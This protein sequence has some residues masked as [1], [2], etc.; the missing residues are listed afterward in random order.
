MILQQEKKELED[1]RHKVASGEYDDKSEKNNIRKK[2]KKSS[3]FSDEE[4]SDW[5]M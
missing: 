4:E 1:Y 3:Y 2:I 5:K